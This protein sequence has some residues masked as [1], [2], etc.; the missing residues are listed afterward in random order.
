MIKSN[1]DFVLEV[2]KSYEMEKVL[3]DFKDRFVEGE[4]ISREDYFDFCGNYV[5]D[6]SEGYYIDLNWKWIE[7]GGDWD[8]YKD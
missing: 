1:Y 2:I 4:N 5:D 3:S 7:S 6:V 8:V